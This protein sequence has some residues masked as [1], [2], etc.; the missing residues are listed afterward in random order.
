MFVSRFTIFMLYFRITRYLVMGIDSTNWATNMCLNEPKIEAALSSLSNKATA[1]ND[2]AN[3]IWGESNGLHGLTCC[4]KCLQR[5][6]NGEAGYACG[7]CPLNSTNWDSYNGASCQLSNDNA[8]VTASQGY[9]MQCAKNAE[10]AGYAGSS[11]DGG[12][13]FQD[14]TN[15]EIFCKCPSQMSGQTENCVGGLQP[16]CS[17]GTCDAGGNTGQA[18][19]ETDAQNLNTLNAEASQDSAESDESFFSKYWYWFV[20]GIVVLEHEIYLI[21]LVIRKSIIMD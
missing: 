8:E 14:D 4:Q 11:S 3:T 20:I 13:C 16:P 5:L 19:A 10:V 15:K 2:A 12:L 18:Q 6:I 21:V 17:G 9:A 7:T 1:V